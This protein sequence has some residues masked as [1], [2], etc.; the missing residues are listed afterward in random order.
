MS[1]TLSGATFS[2]QNSVSIVINTHSLHLNGK[3]MQVQKDNTLLSMTTKWWLL[4]TWVSSLKYWTKKQSI[5]STPYQ[6]MKSTM[7]CDRKWRH[8]RK[9]NV[10]LTVLVKISWKRWSLNFHRLSISIHWWTKANKLKAFKLKQ[11]MENAAFI[12][13]S[14]AVE[15]V[16]V[17]LSCAKTVRWPWDS[18]LFLVKMLKKGLHGAWT[19][20]QHLICGPWDQEMFRQFCTANSWN[21]DWCLLSNNKEQMAMTLEKPLTLLLLVLP[22]LINQMIRLMFPLMRTSW[23][24]GP[25]RMTLHSSLTWKRSLLGLYQTLSKMLKEKTIRTSEFIQKDWASFAIKKKV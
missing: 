13:K 20:A 1:S 12:K 15:I 3:S 4:K 16:A 11:K 7:K 9:P 25:K 22:T 5:T 24:F 14:N 10:R 21:T 23:H 18:S 8:K 17:I 19:C 2:I 6:R